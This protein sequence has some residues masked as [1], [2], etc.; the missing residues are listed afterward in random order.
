MNGY[1]GSSFLCHSLFFVFYLI[2]GA[3]EKHLSPAE[4]II[5]MSISMCVCI[6]VQDNIMCYANVL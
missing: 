5:R 6:S 4:H 1:W 3:F 2:V